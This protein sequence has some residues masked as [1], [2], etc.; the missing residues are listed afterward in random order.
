[1]LTT[2]TPILWAIFFA[3]VITVFVLDM[4][5]L[6]RHAKHITVGK[7]LLTAACWISL[8]LAFGV[9]I[10]F[11]VGSEAGTE[12]FAAY[13][14]EEMLSVDNLF[15]FI[16][17]MAY[18]C[19][20][21]EQ[22]YKV[23]FYGIIGAIVFRVL[24]ITAGIGLLTTFDWMVY[25]FGAILI[26]T[27]YKTVTQKDDGEENKFIFKLSKRFKVS[28]T[29][30]GDKM[31]T[32][33]DGVRLMTPL[34]LCIIVIA[35]TDLMFAFDSIPAVLAITTD[36][37]IALTSN[38]FAVLGLRALFFAIKGSMEH[39][40]YL[41]YGLGVILAFVGVKMIVS[42]LYPDYSVDVV[43]SLAF[44]LIVLAVTVAVSLLVRKRREKAAG[45]G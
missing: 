41:K 29:Y 11:E 42:H 30:D 21:D 12:F 20:P 34:M 26:Y 44:I 2:G 17:V 6:N 24:F 35:L 38:I 28:P 40:E 31:F 18:F 15:M 16:V 39:I 22:Q 36:N 43:F 10:F 27:A 13:I 7:S 32:R 19:V 9:L 25:I 1:M 4:F 37:F 5:V 3:V 33:K 14:V 23:L 8:A 45:T